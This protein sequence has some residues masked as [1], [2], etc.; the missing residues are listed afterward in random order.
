MTTNPD[1]G[2]GHKRAPRW[3]RLHRAC[4]WVTGRTRQAWANLPKL[5]RH[6]T[7]RHMTFSAVIIFGGAWLLGRVVPHVPGWAATIDG[8]LATIDQPVR[9]YLLAHTQALP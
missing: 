5:W 4:G 1:G 3:H 7:A 9:H 6:E 8:T 2:N